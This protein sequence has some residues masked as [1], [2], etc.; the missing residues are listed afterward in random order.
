MINQKPQRVC[1]S[2]WG[3]AYLEPFHL[4]STLAVSESVS[5]SRGSRDDC[6]RHRFSQVTFRHQKSNPVYE[7]ISDPNF[8]LDS[9][10]FSP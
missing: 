8:N 5:F 4:E 10:S 7:F 6:Y 1:S 9:G 2:R 3:L